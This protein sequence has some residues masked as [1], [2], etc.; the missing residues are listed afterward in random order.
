[1][2]E[3][4]VT[5]EEFNELKGKFNDLLELLDDIG[6]KKKVDFST[7]EVEEDNLE[8]DEDETDEVK[9]EEIV[10]QEEINL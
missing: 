10:K 3:T 9:E 5:K 4:K 6:L 1:M 8:Y 2:V 7:L